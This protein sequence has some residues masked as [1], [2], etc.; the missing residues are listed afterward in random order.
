M[1]ARNNLAN[2]KGYKKSFQILA[3]S[4]IESC[5]GGG[6]INDMQRI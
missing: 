2:S 3:D 1:V 5:P 4:N 6:D